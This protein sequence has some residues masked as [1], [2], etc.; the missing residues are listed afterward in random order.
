MRHRLQRYASPTAFALLATVLIAWDGM[1]S[2]AFTDYETEAE[3]SFQALRAGHLGAFLAHLPAYGGSLILRAPF[4]LAPAL[5]GG[6]SL[7]LF[8][9]VAVPCLLAAVVL[10]L[11]LWSRREAAGRRRAAWVALALC[12]LNPASLRALEIGH[13][14]ELLGACLCVGAVLAAL[15]ERPTLAGLL[16]G[17]ALANKAWAV[18]A[19]PPVLLT[20]RSGRLRAGSVGA[21]VAALVLAPVFLHGGAGVSAAQATSTSGNVPFHPWQ[22][23]WFF[24]HHHHLLPGQHLK[25]GYRVG[26]DWLAPI[27]HPLV[28]L[29][30]LPLT[31]LWW[32]RRERRGA[33]AGARQPSPGARDVLLLLTVVMLARCV[34]DP[35]NNV[36]YALPFLIA[37]TSWEAVER[38]RIPLA[39]LI[40]ALVT[41]VNFEL[42][43]DM[44]R[45]DTQA[46]VYLLWALPVLALLCWRLLAPG[47]F[48]QRWEPIRAAAARH[49]PGLV[50]LVDPAPKSPARA[51]GVRAGAP[52]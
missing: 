27:A 5:W 10:G 22:V 34:L 17:I 3:P 40:A 45:P 11:T 12:V 2:M 35:W 43:P 30:A 38:R 28:A 46:V 42:L 14:E 25:V 7:A 8:R 31:G 52:A 29:S 26:P 37:L 41:W 36:Y 47:S 33:A 48:A 32:W 16:L 19:V 6:G 15:A 13:P 21:G 24:G 18:L 44:F 51:H 9:S 4:A 39:G 1:L 49:L 20:L 23:W 50:R